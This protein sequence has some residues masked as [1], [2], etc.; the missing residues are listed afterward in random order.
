MVMRGYFGKGDVVIYVECDYDEVID[1]IEEGG[2][3]MEMNRDGEYWKK[4]FKGYENWIKNFNGCGVVG[5]NIKEYEI[6]EEVECVD[7]VID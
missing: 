1:G 2:G 7:G 3:E 6:E 4:V 5:V